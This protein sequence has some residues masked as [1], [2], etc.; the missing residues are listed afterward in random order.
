MAMEAIK[1]NLFLSL[2]IYL[3]SS[4]LYSH[5]KTTEAQLVSQHV[6]TQIKL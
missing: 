6:M 4:F 3:F 5:S 2:Y 1:F